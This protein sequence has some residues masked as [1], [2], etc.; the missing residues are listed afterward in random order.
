MRVDLGAQC[1]QGE[2]AARFQA[3]VLQQYAES[4]GERAK[5]LQ[6]LAEDGAAVRAVV[7]LDGSVVGDGG[8]GLEDVAEY[9]LGFGAQS[10]LVRCLLQTLEKEALRSG[11]GVRATQ[12]AAVQVVAERFT[13]ARHG[14]HNG[15]QQQ[16]ARDQW[17]RFG[18]QPEPECGRDEREDEIGAPL[19]EEI[20]EKETAARVAV[21]E[22]QRQR[23]GSHGET[24]PIRWREHRRWDE[25]HRG[26]QLQGTRAARGAA[27]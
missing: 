20:E 24:Q 17:K 6:I 27:E 12:E 3:A 14:P 18:D 15:Q 19:D 5:E 13:E 4:L 8:V 2:V 10:A 7:E 25:Q 1:F 26:K 21:G 23:E 9:A 16:S 22:Q 11:R